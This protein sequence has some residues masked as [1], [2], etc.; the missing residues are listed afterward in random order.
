MGIQIPITDVS[1]SKVVPRKC[2]AFIQY[3][4][5]DVVEEFVEIVNVRHI[6][7]INKH[8]IF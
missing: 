4:F 1:H 6:K 3:I 7:G 8:F 2:K 5:M